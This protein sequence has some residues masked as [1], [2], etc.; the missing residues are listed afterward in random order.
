MATRTYVTP[1]PGAGSVNLRAENKIDPANLIGMINEGARLEYVAQI[2]SW[3]VAK[4]HVST[5]SAE[6]VNANRIRAKA[7][8]DF[9]NV[10]TSPVV[11]NNTDV[12][13]LK[14][15]QTLELISASSEWLVGKVY[16]STSWCDL[17]TEGQPDVQVPVADGFDSPL[18][19]PQERASAQVWPGGWFDATPYGTRYDATGRWA[20]HT[21]ADLNLPGDADA[22]APVCASADGVVRA[23]AAY[24]VWGN[25]ITIEHRLADGTSVWTRYGHLND[26]SVQTNQPVKRGQMIG[27]VGN[28]F[29][30][31]AYHLH[32]DVARVDLGK[33]PADWSGDDLVRVRR[34]YLDPLAFLNA[35]RPA[36]AKPAV[37]LLIGLHDR[38]GGRWMKQNGLK[39]VCLALAQVQD[40]PVPLD[41]SGLANAGITVLL[42][43][44]Y[45]YADGTGTIA[46]PDKLAAFED[47]VAQTLNNAKGVAAAHYCN[48]INNASEGPGWNPKPTRPAPIT[49]R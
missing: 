8:I 32:F 22:L 19:T 41:F 9:A 10:R 39:G 30:R 37:Q 24:P 4:A 14:Q 6:I 35:H 23:S 33:N 44:G 29:N 42:R 15:G 43:V 48:E 36:Q 21:G 13:D 34:D 16:L 3:Y 5:L 49:L 38:E 40:Q 20:I 7:T 31:Y 12:G 1:K 27:R 26:M 45:G 2:D 11:E 47:A 25:L 46:P 28:A 18:G 17:I